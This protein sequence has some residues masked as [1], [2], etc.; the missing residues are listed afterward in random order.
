MARKKQLGKKGQVFDSMAALMTGLATVAIV[1][2]VIFLIVSQAKT[3]IGNIE[4]IDTT[5][6]TQCATSLSCNS[7]VTVQESADTAVSF[8]PL[9]VIAGVGAVLL[10]LVA[11]FRR[12]R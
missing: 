2:V 9:I 7:T 5:N 11:V 1:A 3:Q 4:G 6:V 12:R 10:G 8:I